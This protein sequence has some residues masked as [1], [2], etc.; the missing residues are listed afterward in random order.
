ML[1]GNVTTF[2]VIFKKMGEEG[3]RA[4]E[5]ASEDHSLFI[6]GK[7]YNLK[8]KLIKGQRQISKLLTAPLLLAA[9]LMFFKT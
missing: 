1:H 4:V 3:I 2:D 9:V 8:P 5:L 7:K 6:S